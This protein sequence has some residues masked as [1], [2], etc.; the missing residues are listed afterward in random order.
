MMTL[1]LMSKTGFYSIVFIYN[2]CMLRTQNEHYRKEHEMEQVLP[3]YIES[4]DK[5]WIVGGRFHFHR[6]FSCKVES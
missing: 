4:R 1:M 5:L 2:T 3:K 6:N